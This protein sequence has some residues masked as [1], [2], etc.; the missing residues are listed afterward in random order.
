MQTFLPSPLVK[1]IEKSLKRAQLIDLERTFVESG[2]DFEYFWQFSEAD[3]RNNIFNERLDLC[4]VVYD[5]KGNKLKG[6]FLQAVHRGDVIFEDSKSDHPIAYYNGRKLVGWGVR[7]LPSEFKLITEF[8]PLYWHH[9]EFD[10]FGPNLLPFHWRDF[11]D[12]LTVNDNIVSFNHQGT[13]YVIT[14]IFDESYVFKYE[15]WFISVTTKSIIKG[16]LGYH[17]HQRYLM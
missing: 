16:R 10:V 17:L 8:P 5:T 9:A 14:N 13:K 7:V 4:G 15:V 1:L 3:D 11:K 6:S 12:N 2:Q